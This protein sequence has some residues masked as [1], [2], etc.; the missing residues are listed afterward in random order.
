MRLLR[1]APLVAV[2]SILL[3]PSGAEQRTPRGEPLLHSTPLTRGERFF[4]ISFPQ[5]DIDVKDTY[6]TIY[7][8]IPFD[9]GSIV[10]VRALPTS[11]ARVHHVFLFLCDKA[12]KEEEPMELNRVFDLTAR[13]KAGVEVDAQTPGRLPEQGRAA[14]GIRQH[15]CG[16]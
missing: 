4:N 9:V 1:C 13:M 16:W 6:Q 14:A 7:L 3:R 11:P 15:E 5:R 8:D 10:G 12:G 2:L